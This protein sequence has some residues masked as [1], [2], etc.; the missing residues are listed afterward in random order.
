MYI[1][2]QDNGGYEAGTAIAVGKNAFNLA[3]Y[4]IKH[5]GY[6]RGGWSLQ[7][8][9]CEGEYVIKGDDNSP[10]YWIKTILE[11]SSVGE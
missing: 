1:L 7:A 8:A 3:E 5:G 4:A 9:D 6:S 2:E 10:L 11:V